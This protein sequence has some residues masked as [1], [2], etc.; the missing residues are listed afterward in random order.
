MGKRFNWN[1]TIAFKNK[2][3]EYLLWVI[4]HLTKYSWVRLLKGKHGKTV[5]DAFIE[6]V[7]ESIIF[8]DSKKLKIVWIKITTFFK[9]G[10]MILL[11]I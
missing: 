11:C 10:Q 1:G 9:V 5:I 3:V 2:T 6:I 4:D 8:L 7:N